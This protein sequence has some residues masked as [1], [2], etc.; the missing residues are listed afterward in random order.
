MSFSTKSVAFQ[1]VGGFP[2]FSEDVRQHAQVVLISL[3]YR[4]AS[5]GGR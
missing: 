3:N 5:G 2:N 1:G 4:F